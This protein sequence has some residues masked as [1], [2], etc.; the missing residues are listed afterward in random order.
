[1]V[2]I[3]EQVVGYYFKTKED[4]EEH[5]ITK[6]VGGIKTVNGIF[7]SEWGA[8]TKWKWI[9]KGEDKNDKT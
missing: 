9:D 7:V 2:R 5:D 1:M 4:A 8:V 6:A 3:R